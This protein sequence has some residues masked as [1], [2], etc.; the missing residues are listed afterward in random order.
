MLNTTILPDRVTF[1]YKDIEKALSIMF[2]LKD[3]EIRL[4]TVWRLSLH[5]DNSRDVYQRTAKPAISSLHDYLNMRT[6]T[7]ARYEVTI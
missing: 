5:S 4:T 1:V 6:C 7:Y 2:L 3:Y